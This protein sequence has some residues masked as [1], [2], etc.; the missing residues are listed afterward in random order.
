LELLDG[1]RPLS[2]GAPKQKALFALLLVRAGTV[3][4]AEELI[5]ELWEGRPPAS[6]VTNLRSYA[7][8]VRRVLAA[9]AVAPV[10]DRRGSGYVLTLG[11]TDV[12]LPRFRGL[13]ATGRAA[14]DDGDLSLAVDRLRAALGLWRGPALADVPIG[15]AL[16]AWRVAVQEQRFGA[17]EDHA[18]SLLRLGMVE[19]AAEQASDLLSA[20]PLRERAFAQLMR[21]RYQAGDVPGALATYDVVRRNLAD[22][23]GIEPGEELRRLHKAILNRELLPST[24]RTAPAPEIS[25]QRAEAVVPRQLPADV[26]GFTGRASHL[27]RLDELLFDAMSDADERPRA[28]AISAI[29]GTAGV[30][31]TALAVHW[32]HRVADRFPDGQVYVNLRGFDP[33][34]A[35][36]SPSEA[37]R[38]LLDAFEVAPQ[39]IP[40]TLSGQVGLY[41]STL[42]GRRVLVVLDN[43]RDSEQVRPLLPGTLGCLVVVTSRSQLSGL[44]AVDGAH[45][46][47]VD[48]LTVAEAR[49][50]L[51]RRLGQDR[52]ATSPEAVDQIIISCARLPM[53]LAIVIARAA[54]HPGFSLAAIATQLRQARGRLDAFDNGD[55]VTTMRAVFSWSYHT[56]AEAAASLFRL[57]GLHPGLDITATAA[58]SLAGLPI[59]QV[60]PALAELAH[61]HLLT[62]HTVGRY[63]FHD[64]LRAY[65]GELAEATDSDAVR[66]AAIRRDL[67]HYLH[68]AYGADRLLRPDREPITLD[69]PQPGVTPEA[70]A[71]HREALAWFSTEYPV[72]LAAIHYAA[73]TGFDAHAW[74]LAWSLENFF[75]WRGHWH[76]LAAAQHIALDAAQRLADRT[77]QAH[78]HRGLARFHTRTGRYDEALTHL[79]LALELFS[80]LNDQAG[81][82]ATHRSLGMVLVRQGRHRDA[83]SHD[84]QA[85]DLHRATG[86]V[87]GQ[88]L[89]LN[90]IGYHYALLGEHERAL[91]HCQQALAMHQKIGARDGEA[92]TWGS[93]AFAHSHLGH[94]ADAITCYQRAIDLLRDLGDRTSLA[95]TLTRLGDAYQ[96]AGDATTARTTW[97]LALDIFDELGHPDAVQLRGRLGATVSSSSPSTD[98][99]PDRQ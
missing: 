17:M 29:A 9:V 76:E 31:K 65:A 81:Q 44:V 61:A 83:L 67:D 68:T 5:D 40:A 12:D 74:R 2:L 77:G 94:H 50:M 86:D 24:R 3:V 99:A 16:S 73:K 58:A 63:A 48:L 85:L 79:G 14:L 62:E 69:R 80:K 64:L 82:A 95:E 15:P 37:V 47:A 22:Q 51:A 25:A 8:G 46:L 32:A 10:L 33:S 93:L 41:R 70:F 28:V 38:A 35:A 98:L 52:L 43:A 18:E 36:M 23:L 39:R 6:A 27:G 88:A 7:S 54:T 11:A 19:E 49:D 1:E 21:A 75:D 53:A 89:V 56:L 90:N 13:S 92:R 4:P 30:G 42:A 78:T 87:A 45:P 57:L 26:A 20:A 55:P 59:R 96:A 60:R 34:G 72:L 97:Q 91:G 66:Q 71:D 84:E